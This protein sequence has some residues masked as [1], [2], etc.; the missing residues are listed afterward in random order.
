[1][2]RKIRTKCKDCTPVR[3]PIKHYRPRLK[4]T[5]RSSPDASEPAA[6]NGHTAARRGRPRG[7]SKL[8]AGSV[9]GPQGHSGDAD[10]PDYY[11]GGPGSGYGGNSGGRP[12]RAYGTSEESGRSNS[13]DIDSAATA[14]VA[15]EDYQRG[16]LRGER[17]RPVYGYEMN[18]YGVEG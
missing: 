15:D 16:R 6:S 4:E 14:D 8:A 2:H 3:A 13:A 1:M 5:T 7:S 17:S 12:R 10:D 18:G 11:P 9:H